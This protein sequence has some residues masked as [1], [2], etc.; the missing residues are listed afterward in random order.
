MQDV[1]SGNLHTIEVEQY[2]KGHIN[3]Y[4][5]SIEKTSFEAAVMHNGC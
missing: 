4:V 3:R 2:E 1:H 5:T